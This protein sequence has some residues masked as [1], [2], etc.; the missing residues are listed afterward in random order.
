MWA[1]CFCVGGGTEEPCLPGFILTVCSVPSAVSSVK[2][3]QMLG[4]LLKCVIGGEGSGGQERWSK[5]TWELSPVAIET[6][7]GQHD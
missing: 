7:H 6:P 5:V 4:S 3:L 2:E 1:L